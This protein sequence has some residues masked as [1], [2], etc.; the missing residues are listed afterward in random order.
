MKEAKPFIHT[1][2]TFTDNNYKVFGGHLFDAKITA[3]GEFIMQLG[4][5]KINREMNNRIGLF[6][7]CLEET[8]E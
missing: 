5:D 2:I 6:L 4:N 3:T 1:H 8:I 7:W